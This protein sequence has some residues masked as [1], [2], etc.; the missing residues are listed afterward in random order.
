MTSPW[1]ELQQQRWPRNYLSFTEQKL[2]LSCTQEPGTGSCPE[3]VHILRPC[4]SKIHFN[5]VPPSVPYGRS[6]NC[7]L[8]YAFLLFPRELHTYPDYLIILATFPHTITLSGGCYVPTEPPNL[9]TSPCRWHFDCLVAKVLAITLGV[10]RL[11][12]VSLKYG[13]KQWWHF[14]AYERRCRITYLQR[15]NSNITKTNV[16]P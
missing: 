12:Q 2:S 10:W 8:L 14:W 1:L 4:P 11:L 3:T 6:P 5:T 9:R 16:F 13:E 15:I 7:F